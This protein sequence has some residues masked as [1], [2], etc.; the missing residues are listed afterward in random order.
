MEKKMKT[1]ILA[2]IMSVSASAT[3]NMGTAPSN[4]D[5]AKAMTSMA[6]KVDFPA[7]FTGEI[8]EVS[9]GVEYTV[10]NEEGEAVAG[11]FAKSTFILAK[12]TC[13]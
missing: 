8:T 1:L 10:Y 3:V 5:W 4:S 9:N 2:A 7:T 13:L 11:A 6:C 12:K